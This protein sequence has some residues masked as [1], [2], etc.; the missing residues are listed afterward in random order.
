M[1]RS[2][3]TRQQYEAQKKR[4]DDYQEAKRSG[5]PMMQGAEPP[6]PRPPDDYPER[7]AKYIPAEIVT[8]YSALLAAVAAAAAAPDTVVWLTNVFGEN[9]KSILHWT[10]FLVGLVATPLYL[11]YR[12]NVRSLWH[13]AIGIGSFVLWGITIRDGL[14]SGWPAVIPAFLLPIYTFAVAF[15]E[16]TPD[17]DGHT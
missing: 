12:L 1:P 5:L 2:I 13:I 10:A 4:W 9:W 17:A 16:P 15:Y 7:L 14:F 3:Q 6:A 11:R 8:L